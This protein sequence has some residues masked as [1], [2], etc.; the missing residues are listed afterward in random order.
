MRIDKDTNAVLSQKQINELRLHLLGINDKTGLAILEGKQ[1]P[2]KIFEGG[3]FIGVDTNGNL[4][5]EYKWEGRNNPIKAVIDPNIIDTSSFDKYRQCL[6]DSEIRA[7]DPKIASQMKTAR[8]KTSQNL[9]LE[10]AIGRLE[11]K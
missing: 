1:P 2:E 4:E 8:L 3:Y 6:A 5:Y 10:R 7:R 9:Q 11:S